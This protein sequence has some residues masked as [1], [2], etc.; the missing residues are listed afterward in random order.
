M[1]DDNDDDNNNVSVGVFA[2]SVSLLL[3][4]FFSF[5]GCC[6]QAAFRCAVSLATT[7]TKVRSDR[8]LLSIVIGNCV[9]AVVVILLRWC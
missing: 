7:M 5:R 1:L 8:W 2:V 6:R 4:S 9:V 3:L